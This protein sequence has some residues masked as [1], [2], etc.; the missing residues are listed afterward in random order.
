MQVIPANDLATITDPEVIVEQI[1]N[2]RTDGQRYPYFHRLRELAPIHRTEHPALHGFNLVSSYEFASTLLTKTRMHSD[3]M[4]YMQIGEKRDYYH[5]ARNWMFHR[6]TLAEHDRI[7]KHFAPYFTPAVV[8]QYSAAIEEQIHT[9]LDRHEARGGMEMMSDFAFPLPVMVI[10]RVLG[11]EEEDVLGLQTIIDRYVEACDQCHG[12][13]QE[14]DAFRDQMTRDLQALFLRYLEQRRRHPREDLISALAKE[15]A[16]SHNISDSEL[17][18]NLVFV[19][20]A[21]HTTTTD[22]IGNMTVAL[23]QHPGEREKLLREPE[24]IPGAIM[25]LM[26]YDS[27]IA[28]G[29]RYAHEP[30]QLGDQVYPAG[31]WFTMVLHAANHDP[32]QFPQPDTLNLDRK[33]TSQ[34]IPFGGGSYFCLGSHLARLELQLALKALLARFPRLEVSKVE[35]AGTLLT[36]GPRKLHVSW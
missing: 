29:Q 5:M 14:A 3:V 18:D 13:D 19:L 36:H 30:I 4:N 22:M 34:P 27:S 33:F 7:R 10:A 16:H 8:K 12:M 9:L 24:R 1:M 25:E 21:G 15:Q 35:W 28:I 31:T 23:S 26:R 11:L 2:P 6:D 20:I 32:A 17:I